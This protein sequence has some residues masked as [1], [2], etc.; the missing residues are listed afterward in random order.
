MAEVDSFIPGVEKTV[1]RINGAQDDDQLTASF[2][3]R[4]KGRTNVRPFVFSLND[5]SDS[6]RHYDV[7]IAVFTVRGFV[8]A[9]LAGGSGR[10]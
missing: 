6:H 3:D 1:E 5:S 10:L 2:P 7:A 4:T 8:R 9:K